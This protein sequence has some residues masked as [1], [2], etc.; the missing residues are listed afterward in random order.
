MRARL[1]LFVVAQI[2]IFVA[3]LA[4]AAATTRA[5]DWQPVALVGLLLVLALATDL[6]TIETKHMRISG[7]HVVVVLAMAL[8]GPA[9]AMAIALTSVIVAATRERPSRPLL[10]NNLA[11]YAT[12]P[13]VGGLLIRG[14]SEGYG[15]SPESTGFLLLVFAVFLLSNVLNFVMSVGA[16]CILEGRSLWVSFRTMYVPVL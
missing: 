1:R 7:A 9:P 6:V 8:C 3:A 14:I 12:F 15:L 13:L 11:T 16:L 10:L 2:A 5:S 4:V